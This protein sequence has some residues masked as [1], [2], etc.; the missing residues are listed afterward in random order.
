MKNRNLTQGSVVGNLFSFSLPYVFAYFLQILYG[1]A[2]LFFI[3]IFCGVDSTT[4][5]SNGTQVM[6]LIT[7][8]IIGVAM[9]VTVCTAHAIGAND[10]RRVSH[11]IGNA[12]TLFLA[13][14]LG[15]MVVLL[16]FKLHI[17]QLIDV[18]EDAVAHTS[19]YLTICFLGI[20]FIVF[21]NLIAA[22]FRGLGDSKSPLYFVIIA[23]VTNIM[24]DLLFIGYCGWGATGAALATTLSQMTSVACSLTAIRR[25]NMIANMTRHDL[26]P[27]R[28]TMLAMLKT[29]GPVAVQDGC[30]QIAFVV[31][32]VIANGRGLYDAAAVGIV[33]KFIG[34]VFI[35][36][37]A[38]LAAI[39]AIAAQNI[40]AQQ[41]QRAQSTMWTAMLITTSYGLVVASI[42]Q[43][44]PDLAVRIF[45]SDTQV[46]QMGTEYLRGYVWDCI[47][48]GIHF[49]FSGFFVA[50]GFA[51]I[52]FI[53]NFLSIIFARI[54]LVWLASEAYP[55]TLYPMGLAICAG[56]VL[57]CIICIVAYQWLSRHWKKTMI[58]NK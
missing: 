18:P 16:L 50:C 8:V 10:H 32:M 34:L 46:I 41:M 11:I 40:G 26:K 38:M 4:A 17:I 23:C 14:S 19:A 33:E 7:C 43:F 5:V 30:I 55:Q 28:S 1:L 37:S 29:G 31:I 2:D 42:L 49:C 6:Y 39:S 45:T 15:L 25:R 9:G 21:Y 3:G 48:A 56:S 20:P 51:I 57:S 36:P 27:H 22:V 52:S 35:V 44:I 13:I 53:H 24:L 58:T 12:I 54:P 47:F